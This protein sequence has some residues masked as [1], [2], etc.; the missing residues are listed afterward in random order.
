MI[1]GFSRG[2]CFAGCVNLV[3]VNLQGHLF[4]A[5]S[6]IRR[7]HIMTLRKQAFIAT[8]CLFTCLSAHA[9]VVA[10]NNSDSTLSSSSVEL[11][12]T[13]PM[14]FTT[15]SRF[16]CR[17]QKPLSGEAPVIAIDGISPPLN[18]IAGRPAYSFQHFMLSQAQAIK[19]AGLQKAGYTYINVDDCWMDQGRDPD[20]GSLRG[21][22]SWVYGYTDPAP[23]KN[24]PGFESDLT[25]YADFLHR[26]QFKAGL[27]SSSG[28]RTCQIYPGSADRE[29]QDAEAYARWGIDFLKY[30][31][32]DYT[33][34]DTSDY[35]KYWPADSV[36][37]AVSPYDKKTLF[38]TMAQA[39]ADAT[40][41]SRSKI[42][43]AES[44]PAAYGLGSTG[45]YDTLAWTSSL[46]QIWRVAGDIRNYEI[47]KNTRLPISPW[48]MEGGYAAGIYPS[49]Q[50]GLALARY[51]SPGNWNDIDQLLIG[52]NGLSNTEEESQMGLWSI[53]GAPLI[54]STDA[55]KFAP[56]Y[57]QSLL[58]N[59]SQNVTWVEGDRTL[60]QHLTRS[61][62]IL[63]NPDVLAVNQ[64]AL[65][66]PGY[67][68]LQT[69]AAGDDG[70]D[71]IARQLK[72]GALA[73]MVLNKGSSPQS[74]YSLPLSRL[75]FT[76]LQQCTLSGKELWSG[77]EVNLNGGTLNSGDLPAH[78]NKFYRIT[79]SCSGGIRPADAVGEI[80][81]TPDITKCLTASQS[82]AGAGLSL[83]AC[84]GSATQQWKYD[85]VSHSIQLAGSALCVSS[86]NSG[87][88][89][90]C[91]A[92]DA[93]QV[94]DYYQNGAIARQLNSNKAPAPAG[95]A[96]C[97]DV[98]GGNY[99]AGGRV[100]FYACGSGNL[101][102]GLSKT[103]VNQS[104]TLPLA[105]PL[106]AGA[107]RS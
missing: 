39:L 25:H 52:D 107:T 77:S 91:K 20:T 46:G 58:A 13:P 16:M 29:R 78:G 24:P 98:N 99:Q 53:L 37:V 19:T 97:L 66:A 72:D 14:G 27:Y 22:T 73:V 15:W 51:S 103:Q 23:K 31:N 89:Q 74:G 76:D 69:K 7:F 42:L 6:S 64:D 54:L 47:D 60:A 3:F 44:A 75:G 50:S 43:F 55:R 101:S 86:V 93:T 71:V 4:V 28:Y 94:V 79:A 57:L 17:S 90:A 12:K 36:P 33:T 65:G 38:T 100:T 68:I 61:I 85:R 32:C 88:L 49:F 80:A 8:G 41:G 81:P 5:D 30:D 10:L 84:Q 21:A 34:R 1:T 105:K 48:V 104:W 96:S 26:M 2:S 67:R 9:N 35:Y 18:E 70:I 63:T 92:N 87:T 62:A 56:E 82:A 40:R 95:G 102:G 59:P 45:L 106:V 11:A 83:Q